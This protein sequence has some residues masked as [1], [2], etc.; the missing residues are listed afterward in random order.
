MDQLL[1]PITQH[2]PLNADQARQV[3]QMVVG[4]LKQKL[5]AP[6]AGQI[7]SVL[8]GGGTGDIASQAKDMLGGL[9]EVFG[10]R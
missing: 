9:G 2:T 6:V 4:F 10:K 5:P 8:A 7:D 1:Q 3:V